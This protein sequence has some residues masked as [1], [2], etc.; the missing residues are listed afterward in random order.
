[1]VK[2]SNNTIHITRGDTL[3]VEIGI[4]MEDGTEYVPASG[5]VIRFALKSSYRDEEPL[6]LRTIDN[7]TL[8]LRLEAAET[9]QLPARNQAYVYDI[10]LTT[11][12]GTVDTFIAEGELY[13]MKEVY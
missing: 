10:E 9:K 13:V 6:I 1:M 2:I 7:D 8:I 11:E 5:D 3:E 12:D 4:S